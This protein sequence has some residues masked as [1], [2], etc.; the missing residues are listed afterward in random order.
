M[1]LMALLSRLSKNFWVNKYL[2]PNSG[3]D[4]ELRWE[5]PFVSL[6]KVEVPL[7]P[8][9]KRAPS[10]P[11]FKPPVSSVEYRH[12]FSQPLPQ[13]ALHTSH[14]DPSRAGTELSKP[15]FDV[16]HA[17]VVIDD[18]NQD[19]SDVVRNA[20]YDE[21]NQTKFWH[22]GTFLSCSLLHTVQLLT[23]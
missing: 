22:L 13:P 12:D 2:S 19:V 8:S 10:D 3:F 15:Q 16:S 11:F 21:S 9:R 23:V 6:L 4:H 20:K 1:H 7:S 5:G 18:A 17:M 14:L